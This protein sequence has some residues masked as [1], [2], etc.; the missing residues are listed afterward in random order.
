M[1]LPLMGHVD[2]FGEKEYGFRHFG[3]IE[4]IH[5]AYFRFKH[6]IEL[7]NSSL[8]LGRALNSGPAVDHRLICLSL[9]LTP[10]SRFQ[11][12]I[13]EVYFPPVRGK[14]SVTCMRLA[15]SSSRVQVYPSRWLPKPLSIT[16]PEHALS[17]N[18]NFNFTSL[19]EGNVCSWNEIETVTMSQADI[20]VENDLQ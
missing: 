14:K 10:A 20:I 19:Y 15:S 18:F 1:S 3:K 7:L 11:S 8:E 13:Y 16:F 4:G 2:M 17:I 9:I 12:S 6:L 5:Y